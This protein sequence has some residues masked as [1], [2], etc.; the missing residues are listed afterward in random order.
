MESFPQYTKYVF[1]ERSGWIVDTRGTTVP[2]SLVGIGHTAFLSP[3]SDPYVHF[4][5]H[6]EEFYLLLH[7]ELEFS[8]AGI[9]LTLQPHELLMVLPNIPHAI[10]GGKGRIEHFGIRAPFTS[11][12]QIVSDIPAD[13]PEATNSDREIKANWGCR[14]PLTATENQNCWLIGWGA[15]KQQSSHLIL[16]Y[17]NF[18]TH[19]LANAGIRTRLRMHYHKEAWEYYVALRGKKVLQIEDELVTVNAG[20]IVEVPPHVRHNVYRREAPY[21]GFTLRVP[22]TDESDKVEDPQ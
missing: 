6:S 3:W 16:A 7:G 20:E 11:D 17:L 5:K 15:I 1:H 21:E 13:F 9:R 18:S 10:I 14:I 8:I 22:I 4:H 2:H 12:K 19:K